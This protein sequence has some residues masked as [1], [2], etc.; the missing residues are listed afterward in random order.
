[1]SHDN[2]S[3]ARTAIEELYREEWARLVASLAR[4]FRDLDVAEEAASEAFL[5]AVEHWH[6]AAAAESRWLADDDGDTPGDRP[7]PSRCA[8]NREVRGDAADDDPH[9]R[10]AVARCR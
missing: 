4:R 10:Q 1:M 7:D 5:A 6:A 2:G 3:H 9:D 8:T